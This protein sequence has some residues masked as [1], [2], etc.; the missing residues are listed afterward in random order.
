MENRFEYASIQF[1]FAQILQIWQLLDC[2]YIHN[3]REVF[4]SYNNFTRQVIPNPLAGWHCSLIFVSPVVNRTLPPCCPSLHELKFL[5]F[6]TLWMLPSGCLQFYHIYV[7]FP[8]FS[9]QRT[10]RTLL[11][12]AWCPQPL[13]EAFE[14]IFIWAWGI[15]KISHCID[16]N[17]EF[18]S[19]VTF[20][21]V[22]RELLSPIKNCLITFPEF[23][24]TE[25][26]TIVVKARSAD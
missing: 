6:V 25:R 19:L 14:L 17:F 24:F 7:G 18:T 9:W 8:L 16:I 15:I 21:L 1:P 4:R 10:P 5:L 22:L 11:P 20:P 12:L 2:F 26:I 23:G 13:L 3:S